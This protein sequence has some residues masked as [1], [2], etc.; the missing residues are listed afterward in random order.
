MSAAGVFDSFLG[1]NAGG[2]DGWGGGALLSSGGSGG[3]YGTAGGGTA[4]GG[5]GG[6]GG[7][8]GTYNFMNATAGGQY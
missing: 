5:K 2:A 8:K 4:G 3:A 6:R 7:G 1:A